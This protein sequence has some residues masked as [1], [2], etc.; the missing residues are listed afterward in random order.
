MSLIIKRIIAFYIDAFISAISSL[1]IY[2]LY[3][4]SLINFNDLLQAKIL[5]ILQS[6]ILIIYY[7]IAEYK[8]NI[9]LGK[10]LMKLKVVFFT[11]KGEKLNAII[12]R[13]L[14]RLIPFDILSFALNN[15]GD[16]WHDTLSKTR[17]VYSKD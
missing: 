4:S 16:L 15:K 8:F 13:T 2:Y 7:L 1:L 9:T 10:K 5:A 11:S 6:I 12:I 3:S 17:V 14:S